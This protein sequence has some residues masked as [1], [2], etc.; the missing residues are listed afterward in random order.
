MEL[1]HYNCTLDEKMGSTYFS[2]KSTDNL[3]VLVFLMKSLIFFSFLTGIFFLSIQP[4]RAISLKGFE[5]T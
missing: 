1:K 5:I 4:S 2:V 3:P